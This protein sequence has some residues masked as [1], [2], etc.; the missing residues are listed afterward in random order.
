MIAT[1]AERSSHKA[2]TA[3]AV[4]IEIEVDLPPAKAAALAGRLGRLNTA[5]AE[6]NSAFRRGNLRLHS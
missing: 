6:Y 4:Q 1:E 5:L 2:V 3:T